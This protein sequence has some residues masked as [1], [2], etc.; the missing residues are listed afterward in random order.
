MTWS[1][2][3]IYIPFLMVPVLLMLIVDNAITINHISLY[4]VSNLLLITLMWSHTD[5]NHNFYRSY[6]VVRILQKTPL[7]W[8][9][10][11]EWLKLSSSIWTNVLPFAEFPHDTLYE[12]RFLYLSKYTNYELEL[13][14]DYLVVENMLPI[15]LNT[16]TGFWD[17]GYWSFMILVGMASIRLIATVILWY[18]HVLSAYCS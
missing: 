16:L 3:Y 8:L 7:A 5:Q 14:R 1:P 2:I 6:H 10:D 15:H 12:N 18:Y 4:V 11:I 13:L 17:M 9:V